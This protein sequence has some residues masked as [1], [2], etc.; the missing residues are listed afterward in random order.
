M[1]S[2]KRRQFLKNIQ[3]EASR[4]QD[5]VDRLL[6][7]SALESR[8]QLREVESIVVS[9]LA[10]DV[11]ASL[12]PLAEAKNLR[13]RTEFDESVRIQGERFLVRQAMANLI[14]N[15]VDFSPAG[16][17]IAISV[18]RVGQLA[19]IVVRDRGPGVPDY[20]LPRVFDR[21]YSLRRP[22][23]GLKG[24]GL[25]LTFVREAA[26]LHGGDARIENCPDGGAQAVLTLPLKT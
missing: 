1:P 4:M 24:S 9:E 15:A 6:Q 3:T 21:F 12:R 2:E 19:A 20:A 7:L 23:S 25:G 26:L 17:E 18:S 8:K 10:G 14:Q 13:F 22:D 5:F 11:I 16:Q